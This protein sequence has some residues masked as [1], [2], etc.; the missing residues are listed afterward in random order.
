MNIRCAYTSLWMQKDCSQSL[1]ALQF[2][3]KFKDMNTM[4]SKMTNFT[5]MF[6]YNLPKYFLTEL[7]V[8]SD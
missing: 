8:G 3:L 7:L 2:Y 6:I 4:L 1:N 5:K